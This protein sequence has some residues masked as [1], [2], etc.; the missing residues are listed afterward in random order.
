MSTYS[1]GA[2]GDTVKKN[3]HTRLAVKLDDGL[4]SSRL[5]VTATITVKLVK[6][7]GEY[8]YTPKGAFEVVAK[9]TSPTEKV[10]LKVNKD[11][12]TVSSSSD[13]KYVVYKGT[14]TLRRSATEDREFTIRAS[15]TKRG[16]VTGTSTAKL[17]FT[18]A[19]SATMAPATPLVKVTKVQ[20]Y[21]DSATHSTK[22]MGHIAVTLK[23]KT[24]AS[25][26][27]PVNGVIFRIWRQGVLPDNSD[28]TSEFGTAAPYTTAK[29]PYNLRASKNFTTAFGLSVPKKRTSKWRTI[30][31][32]IYGLGY[33]RKAK[34]SFRYN[35][36]YGGYYIGLGK[37][38]TYKFQILSYNN[39]SKQDGRIRTGSKKTKR[40]FSVY[41][42][43]LMN[44]YRYYTRKVET[45]VTDTD[46][47]T[48]TVSYTLYEDA[49]DAAAYDTAFA[50]LYD[51]QT[52]THMANANV[53]AMY[54][55]SNSTAV[56][57]DAASS[58]YETKWTLS[59]KTSSSSSFTRA[60]YD[61]TGEFEGEDLPE[62]RVRVY[63]WSRTPALD[64]SINLSYNGASWANPA[65]VLGLSGLG[66]TMLSRRGSTS[67]PYV[68]SGAEICD[69]LIFKHS[70]FDYCYDLTPYVTQASFSQGLLGEATS[71]V[72]FGP[73]HDSA[74]LK[75]QL[76]LTQPLRYVVLCCRGASA[77]GGGLVTQREVNADT[78]DVTLTLS[79]IECVMNAAYVKKSDSFGYVDD[80]DETDDTKGISQGLA[81]IN[82]LIRRLPKP[83][84]TYLAYANRSGGGVTIANMETRSRSYKTREYTT[85]YSALE[86]LQCLDAENPLYLWAGWVFEASS[87]S[88]RNPLA[89]VDSN[90]GLRAVPIVYLCQSKTK[91]NSTLTYDAG[92]L[93]ALSFTEDFSEG[94]YANRVLEYGTF[95]KDDESI[96]VSSGWKAGAKNG[97]PVWRLAEQAEMPRKT[98]KATAKAY[99]KQ[100]RRRVAT[101]K[102]G[103]VAVTLTSSMK[104]AMARMFILNN[105]VY[106]PVLLTLPDDNLLARQAWASYNDNLITCS[107]TANYDGEWT[108]D[109]ETRP[110]DE[111]GMTWSSS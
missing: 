34:N 94:N 62:S 57:D 107:W 89:G 8:N 31:I 74:T 50:N 59:Q 106:R 58:K 37:S 32:H 51:I 20:L 26:L 29:I 93:E 15:L 78:G 45:E 13:G 90:V 68:T 44:A 49:T 92:Q 18:L 52:S 81:A 77:I 88:T 61:T 60:W 76:K 65:H 56:D 101:L 102:Q 67:L 54:A 19:K 73:S 108:F 69:I 91:Y 42:R 3:W 27:R 97:R 23:Y 11:S 22:A 4:N 55:R 84:S 46:G 9:R 40:I 83:Y 79:S 66:Q 43:P 47:N 85:L 111:I 103:T 104:N 99:T 36:N 12:W 41:R 17:S 87:S 95:E 110:G 30:T 80:D 25:E 33:V 72:T 2:N 100:A 86:D 63:G 64:S 98:K 70:N 105:Q 21:P 16:K 14:A 6:E 24:R 39:S 38:H 35:K 28:F 71:T 96:T 75:R 48:E 53:A 1:D 5:D 82:L 10:C 7:S 109:L